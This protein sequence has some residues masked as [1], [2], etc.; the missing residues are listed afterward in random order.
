[1]VQYGCKDQENSIWS[2]S[3]ACATLTGFELARQGEFRKIHSN[4]DLC[5]E[6]EILFT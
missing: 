5:L 6:C 4:N 2:I 1:M 3:R